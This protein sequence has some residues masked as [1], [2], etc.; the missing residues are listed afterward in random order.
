MEDNDY[1]TLA[2][3]DVLVGSFQLGKILQSKW[4][5]IISKPNMFC[6]V[7]ENEGMKGCGKGDCVELYE[8]PDMADAS[9]ACTKKHSTSIIY[10][11]YLLH[12]QILIPISCKF[13]GNQILVRT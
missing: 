13:C 1:V 9:L 10:S 12:L 11:V 4:S 3:M 5:P 8:I 6:V 2:P 7:K